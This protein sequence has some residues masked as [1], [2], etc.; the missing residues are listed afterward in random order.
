VRLEDILVE[1]LSR[2]I[3]VLVLLEPGLSESEYVSTYVPL[4]KKHIDFNLFEIHVIGSYLGLRILKKTFD[5]VYLIPFCPTATHG[6]GLY[7]GYLLYLIVAFFKLIQLV[8]KFGVHVLISLAGHAYSG[9]IV[10]V[11]AR[12]LRLML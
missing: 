12:L 3:V 1:M 4:M 5:N 6:L 9:L 8:P 10:A 11:T 2:K 7:L